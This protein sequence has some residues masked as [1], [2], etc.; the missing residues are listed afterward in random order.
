MSVTGSHITTY[1]TGESANSTAQGI[2]SNTNL[3]FSGSGDLDNG[4]S[5]STFIATNDAQGGLSSTAAT[6]TMGSMGTVGV[7]KRWWIQR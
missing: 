1:T 4:W 2:G 6:M 3:T 5:V 7:F